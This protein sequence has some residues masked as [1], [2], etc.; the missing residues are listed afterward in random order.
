MQ[1][2][3]RSR[4]MLLLRPRPSLGCM[5]CRSRVPRTTL[6]TRHTTL[7]EASNNSITHQPARPLLSYPPCQCALPVTVTA[8]FCC[9]TNDMHL[10]L[11]VLVVLLHSRC[12]RDAAAGD[13]GCDQHEVLYPQSQGHRLAEGKC[14]AIEFLIFSIFL[15][16]DFYLFISF[17]F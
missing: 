12:P 5:A 6:R 17:S 3:T 13:A 11:M 10:M 16:F 1:A 9:D 4:M 2:T 7:S 15:N 14:I 8:V